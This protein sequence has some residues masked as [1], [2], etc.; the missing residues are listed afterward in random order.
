M[1]IDRGEKMI[2]C[3]FVFKFKDGGTSASLNQTH[4]VHAIPQIGQTIGFIGDD[5]NITNSK[6]QDVVH[7]INPKEGT[8]EITVYYGGDSQE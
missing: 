6:V 1:K 4:K 7:Y 2:D 3:K 5:G 8:H